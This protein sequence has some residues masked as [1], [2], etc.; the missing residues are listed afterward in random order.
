ML[1]VTKESTRFQG[2]LWRR[3]C[4][5]V[6][7]GDFASVD[8][9]VDGW[10]LRACIPNRG[11]PLGP[12]VDTLRDGAT[13][14]SMAQRNIKK[15]EK[16]LDC[17]AI[18]IASSWREDIC[19][20]LD[21]AA[22]RRVIDLYDDLKQPE[23]IALILQ[24]RGGQVGF[25]DSIIRALRARVERLITVVPTLING[26]ASLIA[27][28]SDQI[29][30]HPYG[31]IGGFDAGLMQHTAAQITRDIF[32]DIP[33]LGGLRYDH[34][35]HMPARI[36]IAAN[37]QRR[38]KQWLARRGQGETSGI[39]VDALGRDTGLDARE[40]QNSGFNA[41]AFD[42]D[43]LRELQIM[44]DE[45]LGNRGEELVLYTE[46]DLTTEEVEFE[47]AQGL[48]A[49]ILQTTRKRYVFERDTG[50]PDPDT[51]ELLGAWSD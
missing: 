24:S 45:E 51:G 7:C 36:A 12:D 14:R 25:A 44:I 40:L 37:A 23:S 26:A 18:L 42:F 4:H 6:L 21:E 32:D 43:P 41:I 39:T 16:E 1:E 15:I 35:P 48:P 10:L 3:I 9:E 5:V 50:R 38:A 33:A 49:V 8:Q 47:P 20:D 11:G 31:A 19:Y 13:I 27:L 17:K 29:A 34:D 46:S 22:A 30:L 28:S 2:F